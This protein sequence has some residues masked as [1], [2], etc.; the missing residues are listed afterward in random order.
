MLSII[1]RLIDLAFLDV[2]NGISLVYGTDTFHAT[3]LRV[4]TVHT[5]G[6]LYICSL[7]L[8][9]FFCDYALSCMSRC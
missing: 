2:T 5:F 4:I 6:P 3:S 9:F 7:N 8:F 1:S